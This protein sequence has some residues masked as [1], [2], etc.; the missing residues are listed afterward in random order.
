MTFDDVIIFIMFTKAFKVIQSAFCI[1]AETAF[2]PSLAS[3]APKH[4]AHLVDEK[5]YTFYFA[6]VS[7]SRI[8][9]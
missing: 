5:I 6:R 2:I 1:P 3:K 9:R 7:F 4:R 8:S